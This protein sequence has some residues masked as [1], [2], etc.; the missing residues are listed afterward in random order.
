VAQGREVT[1]ITVGDATIEAKGAQILVLPAGVP[2]KFVN[3]GKGRAK[4]IDIHT[5]GRMTQT[6]WFG[7]Q[8][9]QVTETEG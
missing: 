7:S 6:K 9:K 2:H 3:S 8:E 1:F 5:S 4:H